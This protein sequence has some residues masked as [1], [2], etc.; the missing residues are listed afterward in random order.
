MAGIIQICPQRP[1][2]RLPVS[3]SLACGFC[4]RGHKMIAMLPAI[5]FMFQER[6]AKSKQS[7]ESMPARSV[8]RP[9]HMATPS[10][11]KLG[12]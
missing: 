8:P 10:L 9:S 5:V 11:G 1:A 4:P 6:R 12:R 2:S 7:T 3:P